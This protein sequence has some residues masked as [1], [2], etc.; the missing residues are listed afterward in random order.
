[1]GLDHASRSSRPWCPS[2]LM[3][4]MRYSRTSCLGWTPSTS[5]GSNRTPLRTTFNLP[6][7]SRRTTPVNFRCSTNKQGDLKSASSPTITSRNSPPSAVC[8]QPSGSISKKDG[9]IP[10]WGPHPPRRG[11]GG[12]L[13]WLAGLKAGLASAA[14]KSL[15][16]FSCIP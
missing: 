2:V 15:M 16:S 1:M 8:S 7:G 11:A 12:A 13:R 5:D 4:M 6:A 9:S 3:S 14:K 10:L